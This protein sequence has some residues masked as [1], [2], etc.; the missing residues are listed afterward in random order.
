MRGVLRFADAHSESFPDFS[1]GP[2]LSIVRESE[3]RDIQESTGGIRLEHDAN[4][5]LS[6][7]AQAALQHRSERR[8]APPVFA[9]A[10]SPL[11]AVPGEPDTRE[12]YLRYSLALAAT[13]HLSEDIDL[14]VAGS[15]YREDGKNRGDLFFGAPIAGGADFDRDRIV[16]STSTEVLWATPL[17]IHLQAGL[18]IELPEGRS[19]EF[20]PRVGVSYPIEATGTTLQAAWGRGFKLP[21][22]FSLASPLAGNRDLRPERNRGLDASIVQDLF[23]Q[24]ASLRLTF[25]DIDV[26]RPS[27]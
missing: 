11:P 27:I 22:F 26:A 8:S 10:D 15:T 12:R 18:R 21:S 24:R 14:S 17:G 9:A 4:H 25:F 19:Q 13:F 16:G 23:D 3:K 5:W 20:L 1:G 7:S 2:L 6:Y